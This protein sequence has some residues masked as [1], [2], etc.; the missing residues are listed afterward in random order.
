MGTLTIISKKC[1]ENI[2]N[3]IV[4]NNLR[5]LLQGGIVCNSSGTRTWEEWLFLEAFKETGG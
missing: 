3:I 2:L 4:T 1:L 5:N